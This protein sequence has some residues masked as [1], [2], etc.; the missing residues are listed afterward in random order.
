MMDVTADSR[1]AKAVTTAAGV[2]YRWQRWVGADDLRQELWLWVC[3]HP[4][5]ALALAEKG[6]LTRR[7]RTVGE[8][9][10]RRQKAA[11][12]GYSPQD[13]VFYSVSRIRR[14]LPEAL[15]PEATPPVETYRENGLY[16][17]WVTALADVR[18]ALQLVKEQHRRA[19]LAW[20]RGERGDEA[21]DVVAALFAVQHQLG[22]S[23]PRG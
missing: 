23:R 14:M 6:W 5:M 20:Y 21:E 16:G 7:L 9:Y 1:V 13:E 17:E 3:S 4:D 11:K 2:A 12:L 19:L 15:D 8:R 18:R 10:A 22:G